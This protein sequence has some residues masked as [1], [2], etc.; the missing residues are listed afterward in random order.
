MSTI[1]AGRFDTTAQVLAVLSDLDQAHLAKDEFASYYVNPPG[2]HGLYPL[3]GDH[4]ADARAKHA[5]GGAATGATLGGA[6][7]LL[8]GGVAAAVVPAAGAVA[9]AAGGGVGAYVGS[10][11]GALNKLEDG[12]N[13]PDS[14]QEAGAGPMVAICVDRPGTEQ[15]ARATL[16]RH[17]AHAIE[18]ME[19]CWEN[20]D[21]KDFDPTASADALADH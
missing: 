3:G 4:F 15:V 6:T 16:H 13:L 7:G 19:G 14:P 11:L 2:Q 8:L 10:L 21:W 20:G 5:G 12:S 17:G 1:L 9:M 18:R